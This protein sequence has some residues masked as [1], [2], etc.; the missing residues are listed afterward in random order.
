MVRS[1]P[2]S[3]WS[4]FAEPTVETQLAEELE[5]AIWSM[6]VFQILSGG[7]TLHFPTVGVCPQGVGAAQRLTTVRTGRYENLCW[8]KRIRGL[9]L[10]VP[11]TSYCVLHFANSMIGTFVLIY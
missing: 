11:Y 9:V 4:G 1:V 3:G 10:L 2:K 6:G 5:V 7:K 8:M